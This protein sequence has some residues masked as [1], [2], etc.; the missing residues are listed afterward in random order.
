[1][2]DAAPG[3]L[4]VEWALAHSSWARHLDDLC[5]WLSQAPAGELPAISATVRLDGRLGEV[6]LLVRVCDE[7]G[8]R[9]GLDPLVCHAGAAATY[10]VR[11]RR[12]AGTPAGA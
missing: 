2:H 9:H 6:W 11:L 4:A 12:R 8:R 10:I 1:M 5:A 3:A 7:L